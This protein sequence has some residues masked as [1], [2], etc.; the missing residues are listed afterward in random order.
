M[1]Y[2]LVMGIRDFE[3]QLFDLLKTGKVIFTQSELSL[4]L[5][6]RSDQALRT[7]LSRYVRKGVL[8][9]LASGIYLN[10]RTEIS[11]ADIL[12]TVAGLLRGNTLWYISLESALSEHGMI[13]Q[14]PM[15]TIT[16]MTTGR[17]GRF[18]IDT[19]GIIEFIHTKKHKDTL[20]P[21]L[22]YDTKRN[23]YIADA[24]LAAKDLKAVGRNLDLLLQEQDI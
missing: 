7:T 22:V 15:S 11:S 2:I 10:P 24:I 21:H 16:C 17:S 6:N 13:S 12:Y 14:I 3:Q 19:Y 5:D 9:R 8:R 18:Q 23:C 20:L 4:L 1:S